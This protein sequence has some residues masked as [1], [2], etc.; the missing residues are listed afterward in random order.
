MIY[1]KLSNFIGDN[2]LDV[3]LHKM[4]EN[5]YDEIAKQVMTAQDP[6]EEVISILVPSNMDKPRFEILGKVMGSQNILGHLKA[7]FRVL[8]SKIETD[9]NEDKRKTEVIT[10]FF[11]D[12]ALPI[13]AFQEVE[14]KFIDV[15]NNTTMNSFEYVKTMRMSLNP[16]EQ[17][18]TREIK[19]STLNVDDLVP[20]RDD[21]TGIIKMS[22]FN[23]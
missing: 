9:W 10:K 1:V 15:N 11:N 20:E 16:S 2:Y 8:D 23:N 14:K 21:N 3:N 17:I 19:T 18:K 12:L 6:S 22:L 4:K 5:I 13:F 7:T